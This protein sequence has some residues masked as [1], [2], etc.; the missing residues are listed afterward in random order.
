M[1]KETIKREIRQFTDSGPTEVETLEVVWGRDTGEVAVRSIWELTT[2]S[3]PGTHFAPCVDGS[4]C[5]EAS[6][7]PPRREDH[8]IHMIVDRGQINQ[9]I[10]A[11]R[12]ARDA[13]FGADA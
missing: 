2:P 13:S 10:R 8:T 5:G 1:P 7:C 4:F 3:M 12:K 6:H 9:M 11:L